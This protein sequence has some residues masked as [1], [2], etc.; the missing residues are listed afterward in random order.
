MNKK[1]IRNVI[2][3]WLIILFLIGVMIYDEELVLK[4][5]SVIVFATIA[6]VISYGVYIAS[7][8]DE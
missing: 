4:I 7:T 8:E 6:I 3:F 2:V 1:G 5:I